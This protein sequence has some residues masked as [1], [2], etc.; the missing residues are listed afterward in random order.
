MDDDARIERLYQRALARSAKPAERA[1]LA[2]FLSRSAARVYRDHPTDADRL[3]H[4]GQSPS[5]EG[6]DPTELAAW[7]TVCRVVL[8][9]HETITRY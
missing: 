2:A 7:T 8:N 6:L 9:L 4:V 1:S 5:A 3:L